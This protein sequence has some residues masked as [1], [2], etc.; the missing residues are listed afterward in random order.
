MFEG[1]VQTL[2][3]KY[4]QSEFFLLSYY[5]KDD[6]KVKTFKNVI[7][8]SA[9]PKYL[10]FLV[11]ISFLCAII[12][13]LHLPLP[14]F[15]RIKEIKALYESDVVLDLSGISFADGREFY[16]LFNI[17]TLLPGLFM[18]KKT[19]KC[20]QALGPFE[21]P[22]NRFCA[23]LFLPKMSLII[24][25]GN[26][27]YSHLVKSLKLKNVKKGTDYAFSLKIGPD[28]EQAIKRYLN[29]KIFKSRNLVGICPSEVVNKYCKKNNID[30]V[31]TMVDFVQYLIEKKHDVVIIPHSFR[32]NTEKR[33]NNDFPLCKTIYQKIK[34]KEKLILVEDDL[35]ARELRILIGKC[36]FFVGSRFHAMISSLVMAVPT[37][38]IGW[39]HKYG[40]VF[41]MFGLEEYVL[42]Y[43]ALSYKSL[44][45][46][47]I[48]LVKNEKEIKRLIQNNLEKVIALSDRHTEYI[49][50]IIKTYPG[51]FNLGRFN[52]QTKEY[53]LGKY[54]EGRIGYSLDKKLRAGA[55]SGGVVSSVLVHLLETDQIQGA[56]VT[57]IITKKGRLQGR[58]FIAKNRREILSARTS[59]YFEADVLSRLN[60][61][62]KFKGRVAIVALPCQIRALRKLLKSDRALSTKIEFI[63]GLFCGHAS[64]KS[65][66]IDVLQKKGIEKSFIKDFKFRTGLWRG[67]TNIVLKNGKRI[68]FPYRD[69]GTYQ[70]LFFD[71]LD[72]CMACTDQTAELADLSCGDVWD[73]SYRSSAIKHSSVL[74]RSNDAKSL[75]S[76]MVKNNKLYLPEVALNKIFNAQRR[77]LIFHKHIKARAKLTKYI[78]GFKIPYSDKERARINDYLAAF[79]VLTNIKMA[80]TELGRKF[81]FLLPRSLWGFYLLFFKALTNF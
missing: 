10:I 42:G 64:Q 74:V 34:N 43:K 8:L 54:Q 77:A 44:E 19:I 5:P 49:D 30:Y 7:V 36:R 72:K 65:L 39:S 27:T 13:K 51:K 38:A 78:L 18:G 76:E 32:R 23:K 9:D 62:R 56:L 63:I 79:M 47:Y 69:Y 57:K 52:D 1:A 4:P 11:P 58:T 50:E 73:L 80:K 40:E 33:R 53:Y 2:S 55:A 28:D 48:K 15:N 21:N 75:I 17:A 60:D 46:N 12:K 66:L 68:S 14:G 37:L 24:A 26:K 29:N 41:K 31:T 22:I 67:K 25:R 16:L 71:S 3:F 45:R 61:I 20:A 35:N 59:V 70:N 81:V 6:K